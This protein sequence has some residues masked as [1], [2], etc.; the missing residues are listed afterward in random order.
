MRGQGSWEVGGLFGWRTYT[1]PDNPPVL[2]LDRK[3]HEG[4]RF[5]RRGIVAY[6][7]E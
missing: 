2:V 4:E 7:F 6:F 3:P 1:I 5:N